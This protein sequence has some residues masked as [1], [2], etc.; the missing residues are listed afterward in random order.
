MKISLCTFCICGVFFINLTLPTNAIKDYP[1]PNNSDK[2]LDS[3]IKDK[4]HQS[5]KF[6]PQDYPSIK[7]LCICP[8]DYEY[9]NVVAT[10][11]PYKYDD[12]FAYLNNSTKK[13][14][15]KNL[16]KQLS[17]K[18][19]EVSFFNIE[20]N[21]ICI[22]ECGRRKAA[23][24]FTLG[25]AIALLENNLELIL[26]GG[27]CGC[28]DNTISIGSIMI[29]SHFYCLDSFSICN[30]SQQSNIPLA[31]KDKLSIASFDHFILPQDGSSITLTNAAIETRNKITNLLDESYDCIDF[32]SESF[33]DNS[34][35]CMKMINH[36]KDPSSISQLPHI[37]EMEDFALM[38]ICLPR[39]IPCL[40]IRAVSDY[41]GQN[42]VSEDEEDA[43][44]DYS[45]NSIINFK[46]YASQKLGEAI[47]QIFENINF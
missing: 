12:D 9:K 31:R 8:R 46:E 41:A 17:F 6:H 27:I 13:V 25:N 29:P 2:N 20:N 28:S 39:N 7:F 33:I 23:V 35:F 44:A 22:I 36:F 4:S 42:N 24:S 40:C 32:T 10:L 18:H 15:I 1:T 30:F 37:F 16:Q 3:K 26:I 11:N 21:I 38:D 19:N 45:A 34:Y 14:S 5:Q 43:F 47:K